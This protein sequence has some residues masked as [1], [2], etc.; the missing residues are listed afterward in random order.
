MSRRSFTTG[1][2]LFL[3]AIAGFAVGRAQDTPS[4]QAVPAP[5]QAQLKT[6]EDQASYAIG[7][8]IGRDM[9]ADKLKLNP[10]LVAKGLLDGLRKSQPLM[11]DEQAQQILT[12]FGQMR[13]AESA[14]ASKAVGD[15]GLKEGQAFLA[16]NGAKQGMQKT[17]SGL[18]YLVLKKGAGAT[19]KLTDVVRVHYHGTLLDGTV[20]DSSVEKKEPAEFPVNRVIPG[21]TEALQKMKVGDKW[22]LFIPSELAYGERGTPGGPIGPNQVLVFEVEL[23]EI[24]K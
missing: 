24:L 23:L 4:K 14:A 3:A 17:Q 12:K 9:V 2:L 5:G 20:F 11:T 10:D 8:N 6:F 19:P 21:W 1:V 15:K 13:Q 7:L 22:K 16:A 18:Q